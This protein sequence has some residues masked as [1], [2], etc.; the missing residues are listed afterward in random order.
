[1]KFAFLVMC[2]FRGVKATIDNLYKNLI[3]PYD[4]DVFICVQKAL[5]DDEDRMNLFSENVVYRELYDKPDPAAYF[6]EQ[7]N[8]D[9]VNGGEANWNRHSNLQIY[10]NYHKMAKVIEPVFDKYDYF[11]IARTDSQVLFPYPDKQL[12]EQ[13]P[14]AMYLTDANYNKY[15]GD[16]GMPGIIHKNYILGML[17]CY[18][19]V[20]SNREYR[21]PMFEIVN[22]ENILHKHGSLNQE[23]FFY[24]CLR[25]FNLYDKIKQ[26][27]NI[28]YFWTAEVVNDYHTWSRPEMHPRRNIISK[29][30]DQCDEAFANNDLWNSGKYIWAINKTDS[31]IEL[32]FKHKPVPAIILKTTMSSILYK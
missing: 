25:I 18:Y 8:L 6:G 17:S 19:N 14:E 30:H 26:I 11:I 7:N 16:I 29:Y 2:E 32:V 9:L 13:I 3:K 4:A 12:F 24:V 28:N 22:G 23:R 21:R 31:N 10:I 15:W 1:M 5:P 20:I 27:K